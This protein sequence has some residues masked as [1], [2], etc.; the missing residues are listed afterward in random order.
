MNGISKN[1]NK[2]ERWARAIVSL[3]LIP[4][5]FLYGYTFFPLLQ[6]FVGVALI[7]N[8]LSGICWTSRIF[9]VKTCQR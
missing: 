5:A 3:L 1:I 4:A 8:A 9:G 2:P 7:Y 6:S